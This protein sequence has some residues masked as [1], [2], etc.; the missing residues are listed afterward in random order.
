[1][2]DGSKSAAQARRRDPIPKRA[3]GK[4]SRLTIGAGLATEPRTLVLRAG[5]W[6][7][8]D[9][10]EPLLGEDGPAWAVY[11]PEPGLRVS[12]AA[13]AE[14]LV[15]RFQD[16][17]SFDQQCAAMTHAG[18]QISRGLLAKWASEAAALLSPIAS[19]I[20]QA[21]LRAPVLSAANVSMG[22]SG[23]QGRRLWLFMAS[24]Q[25]ARDDP[26]TH[27][28]MW[29]KVTPDR[30][31]GFVTKEL[32]AFGGVLQAPP[33]S[34][35]DRIARRSGVTLADCWRE[36]E[37]DAR[38]VQM[39]M[40]HPFLDD[41]LHL[42][43]RLREIE[44]RAAGEPAA[45]RQSVRQLEAMPLLLHVEHRL[46]DIVLRANPRLPL[47]AFVNDLQ[48]RWPA[49]T[50]FLRDGRIDYENAA[51][52]KIRT[53]GAHSRRWVFGR[54]EESRRAAAI[55]YSIIGTCELNDVDPRRY[56]RLALSRLVKRGETPV[57]EALMPW[58]LGPL[59]TGGADARRREA[60]PRLGV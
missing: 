14:M 19:A 23:E 41:L 38:M 30:A 18:L 48:A 59:S 57:L 21:G 4:G 49:L 17:R 20:A 56:I 22:L 12:A 37:G 32:G 46:A 8:L 33:F 7:W 40:P 6:Q 51:L 55:L 45:L 26:S 13:I 10:Q 43:P 28:L 16:M 35:Y 60:G 39:T 53:L 36:V 47:G 2:I 42:F 54:H 27:P 11:A 25:S 58:T 31:G 24:G 44:A 9:A 52:Q 3:S 34:G 29:L 5:Q 1:M 15:A 50:A